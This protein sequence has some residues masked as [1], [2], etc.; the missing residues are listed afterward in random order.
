MSKTE[1][2]ENNKL[3]VI[4]LRGIVSYPK[5][6]LAFDAGRKATLEALNEAM[7]TNRKVLLVAQK[8]PDIEDPKADDLFRVGTV[9]EIVQVLEIKDDYYKVLTEG[10]YRATVNRF[11]KRAKGYYVADVT[12]HPRNTLIDAEHELDSLML[13]A[14]KEKILTLFETYGIATQYIPPDVITFSKTLKDYN[15]LIDLV[16]VHVNFKLEVKQYLLEEDD[17][18]KRLDHIILSLTQ[19]LKLFEYS[20]EIDAKVKQS[21]DKQQRDYFLREQMRTIEDELSE[22]NSDLNEIERLRKD[23]QESNIP[24]E[25]KE[26]IEREITR[27]AK[28]PPNF[29]EASVQMSWLEMVIHLPFGKLDE[30]NVDIAKARQI[31]DR[32]HYGMKQVKQRIIEYLAVRKLKIDQNITEVKGPILCLVGPPGVG[33]TSIARSI[34]EAIDR[35]YIRMSLGGIRDESEIRGHRRTYIGAMAGRIM[36]GISHI[37]TDNPLF[38]LDEIDKLGND[39]RGDPSS[40][41]LEVLDPEQNNSF[42]DHYVEIPYNLSNVLFITT[43]NSAEDIPEPLLDRMELIHVSGYTEIEK[44]EIV[45][46]H[47]LPKQIKANGLNAKQIRLTDGAIRNI[48]NFYTAEAGVRQLE[49][50]IAR[51]C[52]RVAIKIAEDHI[53][54]FSL[55]HNEVEDLLGKAKFTYEQVEKEDLVGVAKGLAWTYAGGD[56]LAIEVNILPGSGKL[57]LTGHL[58]EVMKESAVAALSYCRSIS[59]DLNMPEDFISKHDI[60]IH[61]PAGAVPKDG[62]SAGIT[63]ATALA[64]AITG[65]K[66]RH[67]LAMTGEISLRGRVLEIGG[68]KEKSV[69][70][71]R[72]RLKEILIPKGNVRDLEDIPESV[73]ENLKIT[74]VETVAEV[75]KIALIDNKD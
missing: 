58:G 54:K 20:Q 63:I 65:K 43:A 11:T 14:A 13:E 33:K 2:K 18:K 56:T 21:I 35:K 5:L 69:A 51:V 66:V 72:I 40:A 50:E 60:H 44:I 27:V 38:L 24:E 16:S 19:E 26:K 37:Q 23:L 67:D 41:L 22:G 49:R 75:L 68:L 46:R 29:P 57:E 61:V 1:N 45:K 64:S 10:V 34:A 62:P 73:K 4:P 70:A 53:K 28:M 31:L 8:D 15:R 30:E 42:R 36:Q 3:P 25:Y 6:T 47:L 32:D 52:R 17:L 55:K 71:N 39:F 48:I 9:A 12:E 59:E 74:P 7:Q